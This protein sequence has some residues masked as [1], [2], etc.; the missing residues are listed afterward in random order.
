MN[1][2]NSQRPLGQ[3]GIKE[4][5]YVSRSFENSKIAN[6]LRNGAIDGILV[7]ESGHT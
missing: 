1:Q 2:F 3:R 5:M 7:Y 6:K 4:E